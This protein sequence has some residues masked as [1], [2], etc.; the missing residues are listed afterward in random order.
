MSETAKKESFDKK[1][2]QTVQHAIIDFVRKGDWLTVSWR[3]KIEVTSSDLRDAFSK[4]DM[5]RVMEIVRERIETRIA[6]SIMNSM[7]TEIANDAITEGG[8]Q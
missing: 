1:F 5:H 8:A 6:D 7:A 2:H 3:D 4:V